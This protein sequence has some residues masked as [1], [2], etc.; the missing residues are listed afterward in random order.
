MKVPVLAVWLICAVHVF[1]G[2]GTFMCEKFT[3]VANGQ[4]PDGWKSSGGS[5]MVHDQILGGG[6]LTAESEVLLGQSAWRNVT[7]TANL[8][9]KEVSD[10]S[11]WVALVVRE[12]GIDAPG[13]QF[14]VRYDTAR[15]NGLELA[16]KTAG[17]NGGWRIFQTAPSQ[18]S[19]S[20]RGFHKLQ[21]Q[22]CGDWISTFIDGNRIFRCPR[23][24]DVCDRGMVALRTRGAVV[25]V[26]EVK[27]ARSKPL[28][29]SELRELRGTPLV[30]AHRGFSAKAPENTL[31]A[32]RLAID[33]GAEMAECDVWCTSDRVPV[34]LHDRSLKR[35][36]GF[37]QLV[38]ETSLAEIRKLD[39]GSWKSPKYKG[40]SVPTLR[41]LLEL[42]KGKT[43][44]VIEIK[45]TGIE[46]EVLAEINQSGIAPG[47][48]MIFSFSREVVEKIA[49]MEPELPTTWLLG[50]IPAEAD[51]R[52]KIVAEALNARAS[53]LGVSRLRVD[54][55]LV[56]LARESGLSVFVWTV[57]DPADM[58]YFT[59]IGVDGI[60]SNKPDVLLELLDSSPFKVQ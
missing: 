39:A 23:G 9:F 51:K 50:R 47:D 19:F 28:T 60:I 38:D 31:A 59:D 26:T 2:E 3:E 52:K 56:R 18:I 17:R 46:K 43:R 20:D 10:E 57:D 33:S 55:G 24:A 42:V 5:W 7:V 30:I 45:T 1:A 16:A 36:A 48:L 34:V 41:E 40:E 37:D 29:V 49:R 14:T 27:A 4:L 12:G 54:P 44:L 35:T 13:I 15:E 21:I 53:A 11:A 32:Y 22:A 25:E 58:R 6:E 8:R